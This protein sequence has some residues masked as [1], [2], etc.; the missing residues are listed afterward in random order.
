VAGL[1]YPKGKCQPGY[2][3]AGGS[4]SANPPTVTATGGPCA[5]GMYLLVNIN[6]FNY[7]YCRLDY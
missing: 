1:S 6:S 4:I 3:C 2:Y 7:V 5:A